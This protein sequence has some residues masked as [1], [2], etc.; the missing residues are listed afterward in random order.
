MKQLANRTKSS[1]KKSSIKLT[2]KDKYDK[3]REEEKA[4]I[5]ANAPQREN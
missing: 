2:E 5:E 1:N 3:N 4:F